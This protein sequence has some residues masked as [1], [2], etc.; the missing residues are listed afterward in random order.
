MSALAVAREALAAERAS[1]VPATRNR[2]E[3]AFLPAALEVVETPPSGP[4]NALPGLE[5][6]L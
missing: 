5:T 3:L 2:D 6:L 4:D 1:P